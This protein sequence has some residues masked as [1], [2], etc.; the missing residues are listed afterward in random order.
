MLTGHESIPTG[1]FATF[2]DIDAALILVETLHSIFGWLFWPVFFGVTH[3]VIAQL[4]G[5]RLPNF[6]GRK[7]DLG[8]RRYVDLRQLSGGRR[9]NTVWRNDY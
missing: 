9:Q 7:C 6:I 5:Y 4:G 8:R 2:G 1:P 3:D